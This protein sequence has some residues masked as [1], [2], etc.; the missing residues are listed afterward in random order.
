MPSRGAAPLAR[1]ARA[2][3][4]CFAAALLLAALPPPADAHA[5]MV[6]PRAR[7][8]LAYLQDSYYWPHGL[9]MGGV[10][11]VS[12]KGR[13]TYPD[14]RRGMCGDAYN[15]TRWDRPGAVQAAYAPG[16]TVNLDVVMQV[17]H[18][19]KVG[20]QV[21]A[22]DAKQGQQ[23]DKCRVRSLRGKGGAPPW[24]RQSLCITA[25][26]AAG[27]IAESYCFALHKHTN[28]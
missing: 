15:E 8:W 24:S 13:L 11:V 25:P 22:L 21:C 12:N 28:G 18:M 3:L 23:R 6:Q 14:G 2:F 20:V 9:S 4:A 10:D 7:N 5:V 19:G 16:Q 1:T 27:P 26:A 17:Q